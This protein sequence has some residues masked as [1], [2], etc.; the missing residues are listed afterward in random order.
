MDEARKRLTDW[1]VDPTLVMP[2]FIGLPGEHFNRIQ[3]KPALRS[4]GLEPVLAGWKP[5]QPIIHPATRVLALG[6]CFARYFIL[7][8]GDHG[9]NKS[10]A[11]SP[12]EALVQFNFPFENVAVV[13]QQLRWAFGKVDA[14]DTLWIGK[15]RQRIS[16]T[17][18]SRALAAETLRQTQVLIVTLGLSEVWYDRETGEPLW[19]AVPVDLYD[20]ARQAFKVL[21][22][23]DTRAALEEIDS[24]RREYLPEMK[25]VYTV[26]PVR[27]GATFRPVSAITANS[28]S[29]AIIRAALDEFLRA[30]W[31][32][33]NTTYFYFPSYEIVTELL[34]EP[35]CADMRHVYEYV[36]QQ[37]MAL[38]AENYTSLPHGGAGVPV[39]SDETGLRRVIAELEDRTVALE[40][41]A[42]ERM[43]VIEGLDRAARERLELIQRLDAELRAKKE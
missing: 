33:V 10:F 6:S 34:P 26:S 2:D 13:A 25:I 30:H 35:Y 41:V 19:R 32:Q 36:P 21:S 18:A 24:I 22:V 40:R 11:Q 42:N 14:A 9:F 39:E 7:W 31:E 29:K 12:Y 4:A 5:E 28:A 15:D 8:L 16:P 20:A 23:A 3:N 37:V 27:L 38:F 1:V 43:R 17:D